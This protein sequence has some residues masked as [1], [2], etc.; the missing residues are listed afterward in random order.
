MDRLHLNLEQPKFVLSVHK[1]S[2]TN[3]RLT[4]RRIDLCHHSTFDKYVAIQVRFSK[5][6]IGFT[7]DVMVRRGVHNF[8]VT[9]C[10]RTVTNML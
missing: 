9:L 4:I 3:N 7:D 1:L 8:L 5:V 6:S 10:L 2:K